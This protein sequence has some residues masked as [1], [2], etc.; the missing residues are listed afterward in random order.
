MLKTGTPPSFGAYSPVSTAMD[1]VTH[2]GVH[3]WFRSGRDW[4]AASWHAAPAGATRVAVLCPSIAQEQLRGHRDFRVLALRLA[5]AGVSTLRFDYPA[6]GNS[7]GV[8]IDP[9][10]G[11]TDLV[12]RWRAS[13][14]DAV[15][16]ARRQVPGAD[17]VLV[18]RRFGALLACQASADVDG[19]AAC[20]MWEPSLTGSA[21]LRELRLREAARLNILF[22]GELDR[23]EPGIVFQSEGHRFDRSTVEG[24][25]GLT[26]EYARPRAPVVHIVGAPSERVLRA[27]NVWT[28]SS[29]ALRLERHATPDAAFD[30]ARPEGER[31]PAETISSIVDIV[32]GDVRVPMADAPTT[33]SR[34]WC[35]EITE[36][37]PGGGIRERLL[38]FGDADAY[39][40]V[41]SAPLDDALVN[42]A[43]LI[44]G[45]GI[46]PSPGFGDSWTRF[47]RAAADRGV[48]VLRMDYRGIGD[49]IVGQGSRENLSYQPGRSEDVFAGV[50]W[51]RAR[52]PEARVVVA[53]VCTG[54]YY[55]IHAMGA[56]LRADRVIAINPQL[57]CT[58]SSAIDQRPDTNLILAR[59]S[60]AAANDGRKWLRLLRGGYRWQ[61]VSK[62]L[63]GLIRRE[64]GSL[65]IGEA[66]GTLGGG[67]A[68]VDFKKLFP[69]DV[70]THLVFSQDDP[71]YEHLLA[72]G[73]RVARRLFSARQMRLHLMSGVDHTYS[74]EWMRRRLD[75]ELMSILLD[76]APSAR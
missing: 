17:V 56:G 66:S 76:S 52:W 70:P 28:E 63:Q 46:E 25:S 8:A 74:R 31:L 42:T 68:R 44:L 43:V 67:M 50:A 21:H 24:I 59:R 27:V 64:A 5:A 39:F 41:H 65:P 16:H 73:S 1:A 12:T 20:V 45:T 18:A 75:Q 30:W 57:W 29:D 69:S 62:A 4:C 7:T 13:I 37:S 55:G 47:A 2:S 33:S 23:H 48:A 49:S 19:L 54:G 3:H 14:V 72:H 32:R 58:D 15:A 38:R 51:L 61:D 22:A 10:G 26:L 34:E 36:S 11:Q 6:T 35:D 40:G 71:G 53:G 9:D 60:A